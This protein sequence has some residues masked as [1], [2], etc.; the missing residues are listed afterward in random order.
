MRRFSESSL[1]ESKLSRVVF[2]EP[3]GPKMAVN[4]YGSNLPDAFLRMFFSTF[5]FAV[6]PSGV[7][8]S[9]SMVA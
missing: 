8:Y 9:A 1:P 3:E 4:V 5:L 6:F 7:S 2:P